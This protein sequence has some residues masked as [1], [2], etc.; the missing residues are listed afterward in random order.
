MQ[1]LEAVSQIFRHGLAPKRKGML[2]TFSGWP[3]GKL[4]TLLYIA[5]LQGC[6][7]SSPPVRDPV[8]G[9]GVYAPPPRRDEAPPSVKDSVPGDYVGNYAGG[10]EIF[11][12]RKDGTF[13]QTFQKGKVQIYTNEGKW[14]VSKNAFSSDIYVHLAPQIQPDY[15]E[16]RGGRAERFDRGG[17]TWHVE[18]DWQGVFE[19]IIF[20]DDAEYWITK[21]K[22]N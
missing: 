17:G 22:P 4:L 18:H 9:P 16:E 13:T 7:E 14:S 8:T 19:M 12:F 2:R 20:N 15:K 21:Q 3:L 10:T 11:I 6:G 1:R 5:T